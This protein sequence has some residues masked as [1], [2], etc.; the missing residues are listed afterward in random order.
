MVFTAKGFVAVPAGQRRGF[1][2]A[3]VYV[4]ANRDA[5][6]Y[7]AHTGADRIDVVDCATMAYIGALPDLPGVAGVL[8]AGDE[9]LILTSDR[10]CARI[11]V[12]SALDDSLLGRVEV[13]PHPNGLAFDSKRRRIFSFNLGDPIGTNCTASVVAL[14]DMAVVATMV[15][16][17][18]P[19]WAVYDAERDRIYANIREP[20]QVVAIDAGKAGIVAAFDVPP[21]GPHGLAL[22]GEHLFCA[23]DAG[24]L[25][26]LH[27]DTGD[28]LGSVALAGEPDVIMMDEESGRLFVAIGMPG[29]V[30]V[31]DANSLSKL[32]TFTTEAGAHTIAWNPD[33]RTL[34][35]FLPQ[36]CGVLAL[37]EG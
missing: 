27:R 8:I 3:D 32:E 28:V 9:G 33:G 19:R 15:L 30:E 29:V 14:D 37:T 4:A 11:S 6:L 34:Y 12:Y 25:V 24:S 36:R 7:V 23:A 10:G 13:G 20:A 18:R 31:I 5:R 21:A 17:G 2:H 26:K 22:M 35:A 16:P 1:D